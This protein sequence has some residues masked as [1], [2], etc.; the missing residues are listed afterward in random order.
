[1]RLRDVSIGSA[2]MFKIDPTKITIDPGYNVRVFDLAN[3]PDDAQL[4]ASIRVH[5]VKEPMRIRLQDETIFLVAGHRRQAAVMELLAEGV[6]FELVPCISEGKYV[7]EAD[8]TL[9]LLTSNSGKPLTALEKGEVFKRLLGFGWT[10]EKIATSAGLSTK[11]VG[12][13]LALSGAEFEVKELVS[14][15]V[16]SA[17][18]AIHAVKKEGAGA[19]AVLTQAVAT[20]AAQGKAKAT[21]KTMAPAPKPKPTLAALAG[22]PETSA[23]LP[24]SSG[25]DL[26]GDFLGAS[27]MSERTPVSD[28]CNRD[29]SHPKLV[30]N[31]AKI[32]EMEET[33][34]DIL[35]ITDINTIH[36]MVRDVLNIT[37]AAKAA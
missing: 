17:T 3:D 8:R 7:S 15:G 22:V 12:N 31:P 21:A 29:P 1:M 11:Q 25:G 16:V 26:L 23:P 32:Q 13:L 34:R 2:D 27:P 36:L 28:A 18:T 37:A 5:G 9:D 10:E 35:N 24:P 33:L 19:G 6:P 20:A 14:S 4:K 30:K